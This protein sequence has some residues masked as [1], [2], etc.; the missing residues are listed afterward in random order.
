[1][2]KQVPTLS[3]FSGTDVKSLFSHFGAFARKVQYQELVREEAA[4]NAASRWPL[5]AELQGIP[6][7]DAVKT[8]QS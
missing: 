6:A 7:L 1:M 8:E 3:D 4:L 5:L 2:A